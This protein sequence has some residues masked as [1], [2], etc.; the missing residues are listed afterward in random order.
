MKSQTALR[1]TP[2]DVVLDPEAGE[3]AE[4]AVV[5]LHRKVHDEL[6]LHLSQHRSQRVIQSQGIGG[7]IELSLRDAE[8]R[9]LRT[10][11]C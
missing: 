3:H 6:A 7:G 4:R 5:H 9:P 2:C 11:D 10:R 8:R 1:R